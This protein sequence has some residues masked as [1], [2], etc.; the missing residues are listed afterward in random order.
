MKSKP[1]FEQLQ[2]L[3]QEKSVDN[4]TEVATNAKEKP[5]SRNTFIS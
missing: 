2:V 5:V 3:E 1:L 4:S